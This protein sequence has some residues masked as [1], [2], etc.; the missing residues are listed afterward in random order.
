VKIDIGADGK[1][2]GT[3]R[4]S[5]NG[6]VSGF[7]EFAGQE[8]LVILPGGR[9]PVVRRG[10]DDVLREAELLVRERMELAQKE[11]QRFRGRFPSP[12]AAAKA[13]LKNL[14]TPGIPGIIER[15]DAWIKDQLSDREKTK[16]P[17]KKKRESP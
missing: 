12:E 14:P 13:F 16:S 3:K 4:V 8:V 7:T 1:I 11:Y 15:A 10:V 5:P 2:L 6:Q 17:S 9:T